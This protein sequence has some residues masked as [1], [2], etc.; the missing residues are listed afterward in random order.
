M[1][2]LGLM[3]S[4]VSR[5]NNLLSNIKTNMQAFNFSDLAH[6]SKATGVYTSD[7]FAELAEIFGG[8]DKI[9]ISSK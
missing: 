7:I 5:I 4:P 3:F 1:E 6:A 8:K 2:R 9:C